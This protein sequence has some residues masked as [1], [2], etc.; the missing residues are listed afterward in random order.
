MAALGSARRI[1]SGPGP[2]P[3]P[4][5]VVPGRHR[6]ATRHAAQWAR[7]QAAARARRPETRGPVGINRTVCMPGATRLLVPRA[8]PDDPARAQ[9]DATCGEQ[10]VLRVT[11]LALGDR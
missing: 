10:V 8:R 4:A 6:A 3:S 1:D 9:L 11:E 7:R 5:P 2:A